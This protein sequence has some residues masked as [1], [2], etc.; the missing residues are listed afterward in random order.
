MN[1]HGLSIM[2]SG[3]YMW[4]GLDWEPI[5]GSVTYHMAWTETGLK[6]WCFSLDVTLNPLQREQVSW[7]NESGQNSTSPPHW[8]QIFVMIVV[9]LTWFFNPCKIPRSIFQ[10]Y[11]EYSRF[12]EIIL[13]GTNLLCSILWLQTL[14]D[15]KCNKHTRELSIPFWLVPMPPWVRRRRC[16]PVAI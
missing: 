3:I 13:S 10:H 7:L 11:Q 8:L 4:Y 1:G 16:S 5:G 12:F 6:I 9:P 2:Y 15:I 14:S